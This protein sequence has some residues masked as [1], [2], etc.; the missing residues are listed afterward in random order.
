MAILDEVRP[1]SDGNALIF[2]SE[3]TG[4]E[5]SSMALSKLLSQNNIPTTPHGFRSSF[6]VW[7]AD[8]DVQRQVAEAALAHVVGDAVETAYLRS[9]FLE[10]RRPIMQAWADYLCPN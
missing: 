6:R 8:T 10:N 7:A 9:D 2:P 5:L 1:I 4:R 3:T